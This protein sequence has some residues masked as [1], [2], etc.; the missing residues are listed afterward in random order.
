MEIILAE[1]CGF[2]FGV[3]KAIEKV[4]KVLEEHKGSKIYSVG[5]II[6]NPQVVSKLE[7]KGLKI[8]DGVEDIDEGIL[9]IRSHGLPPVEIEK[10]VNKNLEIVD[11]TCPFVKNAQNIC[12][13]LKKEKYKI[14]IIGEKE[15]PE[16]KS[17]VGFAGENTVVVKAEENIEELPKSGKVGFLSQTTQ[18]LKSVVAVIENLNWSKYSEVRVFDTICDA[19]SKRQESALKIAKA[20]NL[21]IVIGGYNSSNTK[22]LAQIC[23]DSGVETVHIEDKKDIKN[24]WFKG[25][26]KIGITAGA[27]TPR[28]IIEDVISELRLHLAI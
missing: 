8:V 4:E 6:H 11:A 20:V 5:P 24:E 12:C 28:W 19:T 16:V 14:V 17:L 9:V 7:E 15:H 27:S 2:C 10:A 1:N 26:K 23:L 25:K 21:M 22:K 13:L 3:E 18:P